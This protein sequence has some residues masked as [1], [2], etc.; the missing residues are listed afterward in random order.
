MDIVAK[1]ATAMQAVFGESMDE[2]ARRTGCV[3]RQRK[4]SGS[5][6]ARI[7]VLTLLKRPAAKDQDYCTTA[8]QLGVDV[9]EEAMRKRFTASLV[10]FLEAV[11]KLALTQVLQ[12]QACMVGVLQKFSEV[13]IGDSTLIP[14]PDELAQR[15]P[16]CGGKP[17]T[18]KAM[19]K[20]QLLWNL[21]RGEWI[22]LLLEPGRA[23]D[24]KSEIAEASPPAGSLSIF[25]LGYFSLERF[26]R[27]GAAAA[28]WISRFQFG[29]TVF[30]P[31]GKRLDLLRFLRE[32]ESNGVVDA[33]VALGEKER[34]VCRLIAFRAPIEVAARRR[35]KIREK[36][37]D[38]GRTASKEY[39]AAQ[40]WTILLT[41][42]EPELLTWK[43]VV[44]L[45]RSRW[46]IELLF[47]LWKS[48]NAL[49][50]QDTKARAE[51]QMAV[52]YA[53]LIGVIVQHWIL[54]TATWHTER[55]SL[56]K[57]AAILRNW[58][59]LFTEALDNYRHLRVLL[60]R[61]SAA[62]TK[63]ARITQRRKHPSLFQLLENPE[64][65]EYTVA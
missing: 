54:L 33:T 24:A 2:L 14:L 51:R 26:R 16:G 57:A 62:L 42:A 18:G 46:Q 52:L 5:L 11:L 39:L 31:S 58:I 65:L 27:T 41:N 38:H 53:K 49:A 32:H 50:T 21:L 9:T 45:Y 64:L 61:T 59:V 25:D 13:R 19:L 15:F 56:R 4:L 10:V 12:A 40:E 8:A 20:I 6:L 48:H 30:D 28:Y 29:T 47:K 63:P 60:R 55:R 36:A 37:R 34:L 43:E 35:Q 23:S 1:V 44:V 7:L 3:Q 17:G 22:K